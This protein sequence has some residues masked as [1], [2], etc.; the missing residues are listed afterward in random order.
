MAARSP[1]RPPPT[2]STSWAATTAPSLT[3]QLL[4]DEDPASVV[5][6]KTVDA[7]V[8]ELLAM[9]LAPAREAQVSRRQTLQVLGD[10]LL[11][12]LHPAAGRGPRLEPARGGRHGAPPAPG[13]RAGAPL[14]TYRFLLAARNG[15]GEPRS[16]AL[17]PEPWSD[18]GGEVGG[19]LLLE[20]GSEG[21]PVHAHRLQVLQGPGGRPG[22]RV[23]D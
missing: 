19:E 6:D 8:V 7:P 4:V 3:A 1:A 22:A 18:E 15:K 9:G 16:H 14:P 5:D 21:H 10:V 17:R 12:V 11:A 13:R 20:L 2:I 23:G